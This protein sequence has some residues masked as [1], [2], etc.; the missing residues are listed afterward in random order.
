MK[1]FSSKIGVGTFFLSL[2]FVARSTFPRIFHSPCFS[3][4]S[5]IPTESRRCR[6]L[7]CCQYVVYSRLSNP[8]W[9]SY[10]FFAR[11]CDSVQ[12]MRWVFI[13]LYCPRSALK[14]FFFFPFELFDCGWHSLFV[15]MIRWCVLFQTCCVMHTH[16]QARARTLMSGQQ[17]GGLVERIA[18]HLNNQWRIF[19]L[20]SIPGI[21]RAYVVNQENARQTELTKQRK[22]AQTHRKF[23]HSK[24]FKLARERFNTPEYWC[25]A[26][27]SHTLDTE[28]DNEGNNEKYVTKWHIHDN[29]CANR[30]D[31]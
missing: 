15:H 21:H 8:F 28:I 31:G 17:C 6:S 9:S 25:G 10:F 4:A 12:H 13:A 16:T 30:F 22:N 26:W 11:M 5:A 24:L 23:L 19:G 1:W 29:L 14:T 20:P 7:L 3:A 2:P 18:F 27:E